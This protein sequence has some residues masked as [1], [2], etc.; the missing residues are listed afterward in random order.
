MSEQQVPNST[1]GFWVCWY[2]EDHPV[3]EDEGPILP[4]LGTACIKS[5]KALL[6]DF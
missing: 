6:L 4:P 1:P 3:S 5:R 2:G